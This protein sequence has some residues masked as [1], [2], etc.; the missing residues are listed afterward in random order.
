[1]P[2]VYARAVR[3][4]AEI[5]GGMIQLS[6]EWQVPIEELMNWLEGTRPVPQEFFLRAVDIITE[7]DV[8]ELNHPAENPNVV[9]PKHAIS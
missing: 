6:A 8:E 4:A 5:A 7:Y 1:M 9:S 2:S 3:R